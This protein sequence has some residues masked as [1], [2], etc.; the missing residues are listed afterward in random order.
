MKSFNST[1]GTGRSRMRVRR[2]IMALTYITAA[3]AGALALAPVMRGAFPPP[4]DIALVI[5]FFG[6]VGMWGVLSI[7]N[8]AK[9]ALLPALLAGIGGA[10]GV[11]LTNVFG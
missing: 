3:I 7:W 11:L 6:A 5:G 10:T 4:L 9:A 8:G 2:W 1:E